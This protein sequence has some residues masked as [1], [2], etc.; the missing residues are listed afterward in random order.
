E[1]LEIIP[2]PG[3]TTGAFSYLWSSG[4]SK[5]LFLGD[6]LVPVDGEWKFWVTRA[7]R[8]SMIQS[9]ELLQALDFNYLVINSFAC[10]EF[11]CIAVTPEEKSEI[12]TDVIQKLRKSENFVAPSVAG[13]NY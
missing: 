5:Y 11:P 10:T 12:F 8:Q 7:G 6:V 4:D 9:M 3:H 1:D 13:M 2:T